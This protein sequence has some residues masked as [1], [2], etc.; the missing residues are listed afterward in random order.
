MSKV[1]GGRNF[2]WGKKMEWAGMQALREAF[3][4]GRY[5]TVAGHAARWRRFCH[6]ARESG[7]R[8]VRQV[9]RSDLAQ[10]AEAMGRQ[11]KD[12]MSTAYAKNLVTSA[13]VVFESMRRDRVIWVKPGDFVRQRT[14]VRQTVPPGINRAVVNEAVSKLVESGKTR[15]AQLA[16]LCREFGLRRKEASLLDLRLA[17]AQATSRG[18]INVIAGT[19]GGRGRSVD[20]WVPVSESGLRVVDSALQVAGSSGR[21]IPTNLSFAQWGSKVSHEWAAAAK[22]LGLGPIRDLRAAYACERYEQITGRA[23][24]VVA[25]QRLIPKNADI[26]ARRVLSE[27]LGHNRIDVVAAYIGSGR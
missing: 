2:G 17:R 22:L 5:A 4:E 10:F 8:D 3:G 27:E 20:R 15:V 7:I 23:P 14:L 24:P 26:Q 6:W 11:V 19:K 12:G 21:L 16:I 9:R 1:G 25:G 18:Q 13:N